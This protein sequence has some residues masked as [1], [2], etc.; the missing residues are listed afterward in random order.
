M[1][2]DVTAGIK[3]LAKA[4]QSLQKAAFESRFDTIQRGLLT[5]LNK[6]IEKVQEN[7]SEREIET[8]QKKRDNLFKRVDDL[9]Q[10][11]FDLQSNSYRLLEVNE[12]AAAATT[13]A[14]AD[15]DD[16][17]SDDEAAALNTA[18]DEL[19]AK[20]RNLH[21]FGTE[22]GVTD[23]F[24]ANRFRAY[25]DALEGLTA[26]TGAIDPEGTTPPTNQNRELIDALNT[27]AANA[28]TDA[29]ST[30]YLFS[31]TGRLIVD[32]QKA[33]YANEADLAELTA[34]RIAQK[35]EEIENLEI[36][37]TNLIRSISLA[38]EVQSGITDTLVAGTEFKPEK[39]SILNLFT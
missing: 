37:Y 35:Q 27:L 5:Q 31:Q 34:T 21:S 32:T 19:I 2:N 28:A 18:K 4:N 8:L 16:T 11:Q 20:L 3:Q 1:V 9:K 24:I 38:F 13:A 25:A 7:G 15:A 23:G 36:R 17:L 29:E 39:G 14:N 33:A 22:T 12:D 26:T 30:S 10:V 6:E